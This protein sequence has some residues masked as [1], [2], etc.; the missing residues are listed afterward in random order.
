MTGVLCD[1]EMPTKLKVLIYK[2]AIRTVLLYSNDIWPITASLADKMS[3]CKMS[4]L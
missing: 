3:S 2:T 4:M 1:E